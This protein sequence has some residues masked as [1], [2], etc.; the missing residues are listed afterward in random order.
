MT[1]HSLAKK[2]IK[3]G[4][5]FS[6]VRC[7]SC[8]K[9]YQQKYDAE[10]S[11]HRVEYMRKWR[12]DNPGRDRE[13]SAIRYAANPEK[14]RARQAAYRK[15]NPDRVNAA[16][17]RFVEANPEYNRIKLANRSDRIKSVGGKLSKGLPVRLLELQRGKC[18]CCRASL[19]DT[20]Y[21]LDHIIPLAAGGENSDHNIQL[22]CPACNIKKAAKHPIEFMQSNG[23]LL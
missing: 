5:L 11:K 3:C 18:A 13:A 12:E 8:K 21:H 9:A 2:C 14:E 23:Y 19:S 16:R 17:R 7:K 6:G 10:H 4:T 15:L 1:E 20:G 22:L